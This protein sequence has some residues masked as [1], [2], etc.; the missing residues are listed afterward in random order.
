MNPV[1]WR[2]TTKTIYCFRTCV[3]LIVALCE[4]CA[5]A[6]FRSSF[7]IGAK[8]EMRGSFSQLFCFKNMRY[9]K[10][11]NYATRKDTFEIPRWFIANKTVE[12]RNKTHVKKFNHARFFHSANT[13]NTLSISICP[14]PDFH[15][16]Q[17]VREIVRLTSRQI[18]SP[19]TQTGR[20]LIRQYPPIIPCLRMLTC[21]PSAL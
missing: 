4:K 1:R 11:H 14:S 9:S 3:D 5:S 6:V 16:S 20:K 21:R 7:E 13:H 19:H 10:C 15:L 8:D 18:W 2:S 17:R 12:N